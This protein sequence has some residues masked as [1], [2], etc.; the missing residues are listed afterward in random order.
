[1]TAA[2]HL[3]SASRV[4]AG[5]VLISSSDGETRYEVLCAERSGN[6]MLLRVK[7]IDTGNTRTLRV[8][9]RSTQ[10]RENRR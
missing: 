5:D 6:A 4:E 2:V 10:M 8:P 7:N 3:I 9:A 1:M